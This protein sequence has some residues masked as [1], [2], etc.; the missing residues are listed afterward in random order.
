MIALSII[1]QHKGAVYGVS[2]QT[3]IKRGQKY[4]IELVNQ[5]FKSKAEAQQYIK[6][7]P[8]DFYKPRVVQLNLS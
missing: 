7:R 5:I 4:E 8:N 2:Y 6:E 1:Y 3:G